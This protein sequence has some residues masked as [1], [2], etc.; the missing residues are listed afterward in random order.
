V[1]RASARRDAGFTLM[2]LVVV[3][4]VLATVTAFALPSIRRGSEGLQL[5]TGASRVASLLREARQQAVTHRRPTRV[6]LESSH[7]AVALAFVGSDEPLRRVELSERFRLAATEG[8]DAVIF[9]PRGL[10]KDARWTVEGPGGRSLVVEV[11]GI[12]GRVAVA[13]APG[14]P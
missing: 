8:G 5:R 14:A 2:E 4:A 13:A 11:H 7:R 9:S 3:L 10:G 12:T 1:S 6:A